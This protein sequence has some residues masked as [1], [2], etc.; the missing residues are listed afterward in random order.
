MNKMNYT[1]TLYVSSVGDLNHVT[2]AFSKHTTTNNG[3]VK[4]MLL[5]VPH[6][7]KKIHTISFD[8]SLEN[9][10]MALER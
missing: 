7:I 6:V 2:K 4:T 10:D 9:L 8:E 5:Y 1:K 3:Y